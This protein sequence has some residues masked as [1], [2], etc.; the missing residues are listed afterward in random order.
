M[1]VKKGVKVCPWRLVSYQICTTINPMPET[2]GPDALSEYANCIGDICALWD[3]WA[4]CC[5]LRS[6]NYLLGRLLQQEGNDNVKF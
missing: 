1:E 2:L 5:A 4:N 3:E 6:S